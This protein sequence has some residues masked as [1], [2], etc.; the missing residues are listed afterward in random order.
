M[1]SWSLRAVAA[2]GFVRADEFARVIAPA[3][4]NSPASTAAATI[5]ANFAACVAPAQPSMFRHSALVP[6]IV[7]P[8]T[9]ATVNDGSVT[10]A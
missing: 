9:V 10:L 7:P 3:I 4:D 1:L 6:S 8:P 5:S 2:V